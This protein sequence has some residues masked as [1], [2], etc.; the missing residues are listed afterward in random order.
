MWHTWWIDSFTVS[1]SIVDQ[2]G[3]TLGRGE[4]RAINQYNGHGQHTTIAS[5]IPIRSNR[6]TTIYI[7][8]TR[9][10]KTKV[11]VAHVLLEALNPKNAGQVNFSQQ[12]APL[13]R[14][15]HR[16]PYINRPMPKCSPVAGWPTKRLGHSFG[17]SGNHIVDS[18]SHF[19]HDQV[20]FWLLGIW[21]GFS[22]VCRCLAL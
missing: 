12:L 8:F 22:C 14:R 15:R 21:V 5:I 1:C 18:M 17:N 9:K 10:R 11:R 4:P 20:P 3:V 2:F 19:W 7:T 6:Y 16:F 13:V